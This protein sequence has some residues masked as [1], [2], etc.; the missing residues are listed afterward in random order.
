MP[1]GFSRNKMRYRSTCWLREIP[2]GIHVVHYAHVLIAIVVYITSHGVGIFFPI[3][4]V[5]SGLAFLTICLYPG[6]LGAASALQQGIAALTKIA[7][8]KKF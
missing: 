6:F 5:M 3:C 2:D 1:S 7:V 8:A 4:V